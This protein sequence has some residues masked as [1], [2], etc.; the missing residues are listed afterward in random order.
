MIMRRR[1]RRVEQAT[2]LVFFCETH[3]KKDILSP[4]LPTHTCLYFSLKEFHK[5][6]LLVFSRLN[7][8]HFKAL[9]TLVQSI[10]QLREA[11][12]VE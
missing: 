10:S 6:Y 2:S 4:S 3:N 7:I 9:N 1:R 5:Q 11:I 8:S 12:P